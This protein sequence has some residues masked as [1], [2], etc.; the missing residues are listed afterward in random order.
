M[1]KA[2]FDARMAAN[3]KL[4]H[5]LPSEVIKGAYEVQKVKN[6]I[7]TGVEKTLAR[8]HYPEAKKLLTDSGQTIF[9]L[10]GEDSRDVILKTQS[11]KIFKQYLE[12]LAD[13]LKVRK[14]NCNDNGDLYGTDHLDEIEQ[15][16]AQIKGKEG[17]D[18]LY[19]CT[20]PVGEAIIM[21][22]LKGGEDSAMSTVVSHTQG[23]DMAKLGAQSRVTA[24]ITDRNLSKEFDIEIEESKALE[25][26][27]LSDDPDLPRNFNVYV[28]YNR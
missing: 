25:G 12:R 27:Q 17:K 19:L 16:R 11:S 24:P 18:V 6:N 7:K 9:S 26:V 2:I 28:N 23:L 22:G 5:I 4:Q 14:L 10:T 1:K 3:Q 15:Q 20:I 13:L 8:R 21:G